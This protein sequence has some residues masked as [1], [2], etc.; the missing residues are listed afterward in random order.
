MRHE[1]VLLADKVV[2]NWLDRK[3]AGHFKEK[4]RP[5]K[6]GMFVLDATALPG[7]PYDDH[8]LKDAMKHMQKRLTGTVHCVFADKE[9]CGHGIKLGTP[10][11]PC[12][13]LSRQKQ[14]VKTTNTKKELKRRSGI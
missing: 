12:V 14:G 11:M 8:T 2:W 3:V 7:K 4:G 10:N 9:Y 5:A 6:A 1:L 13:F